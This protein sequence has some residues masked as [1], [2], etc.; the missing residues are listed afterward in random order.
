MIFLSIFLIFVKQLI[1][2]FVKI[3]ARRSLAPVVIS[4]HR[5][6]VQKLHCLNMFVNS[7][8]MRFSFFLRLRLYLVKALLPRAQ[9]NGIVIIQVLIADH[10]IK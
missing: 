9:D 2:F 4:A 10:M 5:Q 1:I 8:F 3:I 7:I 6:S